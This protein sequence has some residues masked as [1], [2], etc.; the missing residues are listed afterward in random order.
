MREKELQARIIRLLK[1]NGAYVCKVNLSSRNGVPDLLCCIRGRF[2]GIEVKSKQNKPTP[3][4]EFNLRKITQAGGVGVVVRNLKEV[5]D[6]L[7][8]IGDKNG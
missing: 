7:K 3:L 5:E 2:I 6:L 1:S 4:Q 8:Q